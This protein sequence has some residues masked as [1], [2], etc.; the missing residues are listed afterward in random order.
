MVC[1]FFCGYFSDSVVTII[2][3]KSKIASQAY[4]EE[5]LQEEILKENI[6]LFYDTVGAD[7][8][9]TASF[10]VNKA[11]LLLSKTMSKLRSISTEFED[12]SFDVMVPVSYLFIPSSYIM[13][14]IKL[15]VTT[16]SLLYYDVSLK[17]DIKEYGIN[18][19]LVSLILKVDISYQVIVPLMVEIVD[20]S[21]EIPLALEVIN[22][23]VPEVLLSY[24]G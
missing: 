6:S 13:P 18:S 16:S 14:N 1:M 8:V 11:N 24:N 4:I 19:S 17:T 12:N 15:S 3:T 22:G 23:K 21:I 20:N 5:V 9:I 10:D 2:N 7:G